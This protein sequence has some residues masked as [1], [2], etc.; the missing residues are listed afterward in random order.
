M[1]QTLMTTDPHGLRNLVEGDKRDMRSGLEALTHIYKL[2]NPDEICSF[3]LGNRFLNDILLEAPK[4]I[5]EFFGQVELHLDVFFDPDDNTEELV[6]LINSPYPVDESIRREK[7]LYK[8]WFFSK[9][10]SAHGKLSI[11]EVPA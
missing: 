4:H 9:L 3:L 6:V 10:Q 8:D 7:Q 2:D 5:Y 11:L 1:G